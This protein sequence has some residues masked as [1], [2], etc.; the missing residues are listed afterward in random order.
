[1][2]VLASSLQSSVKFGEAAY[3]VDEG[4]TVSIPV[5]LDQDPER[6]VVIPIQATAAG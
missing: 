6:T 3:D 1:M 5:T 2:S 4:G